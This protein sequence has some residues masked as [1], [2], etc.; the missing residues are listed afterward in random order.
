MFRLLK[1]LY[2]HAAPAWH[3]M[4]PPIERQKD[5]FDCAGACLTMVSEFYGRIF[6]SEYWLDACETAADGSAVA[7]VKSAAESIGFEVTALEIRSA[8]E[9]YDQSMPFIAL[10]NN[11]YVVIYRAS[12]SKVLMGDP[13]VGLITT[14]PREF[15]PGFQKIVL[16]LVPKKKFYLGSIQTINF[17]KLFRP[18]RDKKI[19]GV[20]LFVMST[21][22][23]VLKL[24]LPMSVLLF[25][26]SPEKLTFDSESLLSICAFLLATEALNALFSVVKLKTQL[27]LSDTL[28]NHFFRKFLSHGS[29]NTYRYED[30]EKLAN[31]PLILLEK[32]VHACVTLFFSSALFYVFIL[33]KSAA[34]LWILAPGL[35]F[36][37]WPLQ[38]TTSA[39]LGSRL[40]KVRNIFVKTKLK[41]LKNVSL[42]QDGKLQFSTASKE[43][44]RSVDDYEY[45]S[46]IAE[47]FEH[48]RIILPK[49]WIYSTFTAGCYWGIISCPSILHFLAGGLLIER[50]IKAV[51]QLDTA[52]S[53]G[54]AWH[55]K[56]AEFS[57]W[58]SDK[59]STPQK[60]L[61]SVR[62]NAR[63]A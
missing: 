36:F 31:T 7:S 55:K 13:D 51:I 40:R 24:A 11:H 20:F 45:Q 56:L 29:Q 38:R 12:K 16:K 3:R 32:V 58:L 19:A 14:T 47:T 39:Q 41:G 53:N 25:F 23:A 27:K 44:L 10:R 6:P 60:T 8:H 37:G 15:D 43:E 52:I 28:L 9:F 49:A 34:V 42:T 26:K 63:A 48:S 50:S 35:L 17:I 46:I 1:S 22:S 4:H 21:L 18:L 62:K 2:F 61:E 59:N 57:L 30:V 33:D 5:K 54:F